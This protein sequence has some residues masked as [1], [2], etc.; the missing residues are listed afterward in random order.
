MET[1]ETYLLA[2]FLAG[3]DR[4]ANGIK[5]HLHWFGFRGFT[6]GFMP[7][8]E[9]MSKLEPWLLSL[10]AEYPNLEPALSRLLIAKEFRAKP[11]MFQLVFFVGFLQSSHTV[12]GA[13]V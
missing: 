8:L 13:N 6:S 7:F 5:E 3:H 12:F 2:A 10:R 9:V 4:D 11:P 1:T